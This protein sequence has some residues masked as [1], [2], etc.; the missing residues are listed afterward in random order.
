MNP[1]ARTEGTIWEE[2]R[3]R[4]AR[5]SATTAGGE[6]LRARLAARTLRLRSPI[7]AA[8]PTGPQTTFLAFTQGRERYGVLL[9]EVVE[10][11]GLEHYSPVPG[12]PPFVHGVMHFRGEILSL[13]DLRRLLGVP[14]TGLADVHAVIVVQADGR[15]AALAATQLEEIASVASQELRQPPLSPGQSSPDWIVGVCEE[16]RLIVRMERLWKDPQLQQWRRHETH[17]W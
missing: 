12:A 13:L 1:E 15:R 17:H 16:T 10:V 6:A 7:V 3:R 8:G 2:V 14:E 5:A 11:Q 4:L 9:E